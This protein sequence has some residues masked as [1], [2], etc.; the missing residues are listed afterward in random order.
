MNKPVW[1]VVGALLVIFGALFT[2]QGLNVIHG[3]GMS[4]QTFWAVAG[5]VMVLIGLVLIGRVLVGAAARRR[6]R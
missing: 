3:S 2:L 6:I 1:A 5:P 4:G